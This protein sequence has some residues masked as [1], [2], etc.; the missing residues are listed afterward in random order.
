MVHIAKS[1]SSIRVSVSILYQKH[2]SAYSRDQHKKCNIYIYIYLKV[3]LG[4][5]VLKTE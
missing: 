1:S 5:G 4:S 2:G 3:N